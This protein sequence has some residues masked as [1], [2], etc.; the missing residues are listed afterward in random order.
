M[1]MT[2]PG[3]LAL[4]YTAPIQEFRAFL[5]RTER[6]PSLITTTTTAS[7]STDA[8]SNADSGSG[9]RLIL[10]E[11]LPFL[12]HLPS[13]RTFQVRSLLA[14]SV[15]LGGDARVLDCADWT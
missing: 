6:Y 10:I 12:G 4:P 5:Q 15:S 8:S 13:L 2:T 9:K 3:K 11:D 14:V 1:V 7:A